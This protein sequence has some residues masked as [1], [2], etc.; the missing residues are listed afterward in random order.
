MKI[1]NQIPPV[2]ILNQICFH[3]FP[4]FNALP[5]EIH[6]FITKMIIIG[7]IKYLKT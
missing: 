7:M 5:R 3:L 6:T 4:V 2:L 1:K